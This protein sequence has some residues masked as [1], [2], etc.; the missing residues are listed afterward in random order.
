MNLKKK[1]IINVL[2]NSSSENEMFQSQKKTGI[3]L[4]KK[5]KLN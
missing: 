5:L 1:I 3:N 2:N 4:N